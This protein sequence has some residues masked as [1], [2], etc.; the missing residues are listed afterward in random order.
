MRLKSA[1][2]CGV[3]VRL[4]AVA[5]K[6]VCG[7]ARPAAPCAEA[8]GHRAGA[9]SDDSAGEL[10]EILPEELPENC[11]RIAGRIAGELP[12]NCRRIAGMLAGELSECGT[13]GQARTARVLEAKL[14]IAAGGY[15]RPRKLPVRNHTCH[16]LSSTVPVLVHMRCSTRTF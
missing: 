16:R 3:K 8:A 7:F 1:L 14:S 5:L 11:R 15:P 12:E 2:K 6:V 4:S 10:S 9:L 13:A